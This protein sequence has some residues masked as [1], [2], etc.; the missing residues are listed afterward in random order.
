MKKLKFSNHLLKNSS[1]IIIAGILI[2]Q[3]C[4]SA[5][6]SEERIPS[7]TKNTGIAYQGDTPRDGMYSCVT[8]RADGTPFITHMEVIKGDVIQ[9]Y[10]INEK[11]EEQAIGPECYYIFHDEFKAIETYMGIVDKYPC[12]RMEAQQTQDLN[13]GETWTEYTVSGCDNLPEGGCWYD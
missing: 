3:S 1:L 13:P 7:K 11:G 6:I 8:Y 2:C 9:Y 4:E 10:Y 5:N 12:V